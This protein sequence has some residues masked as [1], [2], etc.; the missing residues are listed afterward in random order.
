MSQVAERGTPEEGCLGLG[1][2]HTPRAGGQM[3]PQGASRPDK[4]PGRDEPGLLL[5]T[6]FVNGRVEKSEDGLEWGGGHD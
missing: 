5:V 2:S 4:I 3:E 6:G 1:G